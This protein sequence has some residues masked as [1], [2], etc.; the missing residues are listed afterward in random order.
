MASGAPLD[1]Q[2][3]ARWPEQTELQVQ[4]NAWDNDP[5]HADLEGILPPLNKS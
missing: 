4:F 1:V 2:R 3:E 5:N